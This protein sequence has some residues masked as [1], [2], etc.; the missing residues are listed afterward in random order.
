MLQI[1]DLKNQFVI[2][3]RYEDITPL[4]EVLENKDIVKVGT[5][6]KFDWSRLFKL[7]FDTKNLYDCMINEMLLNCGISRPKGYFSL[8]GMSSRY[9]GATFTDPRQLSLFEEFQLTK[10]T[11]DEFANLGDK[12]FTKAQISY[13]ANDV[14]IPLL[15]KAKQEKLIEKEGLTVVSQLENAYVEV[16]SWMEYSGL[17]I[18]VDMWL[19]NNDR[20][21]AL[22]EEQEKVMN[23]YTDYEVN[24]NSPKQV[25]EVFKKLGV[26]TKLLDKEKTEDLGYDVWKDS[27]ARTNIEKHK[28]KYPIVEDY[29][30]YKMLFK[31]VH[32]Y[33][34]KFLENVNPVTG[35]VHSD[36]WQILNTGRISSANPNCV[37]LDTEVLT[38]EGW[39]TYEK[40]SIGDYIAT[41][42]ENGKLAWKPV[43]NKYVGKANVK[44]YKKTNF[45]MALTDNH[46]VLFQRRKTGKF[47]TVEAKDW[48]KHD[49]ILNSSDLDYGYKENQDLIKLVVASVSDAYLCKYKHLDFSFQK[50]RK[51][52]RLKSILNS[53]GIEYKIYPSKDRLRLK[54]HNSNIPNKLWDYISD[55]KEFTYKILETDLQTRK[56]FFEEI[57]YWDGNVKRHSQITYKS[58]Q[59]ID[60][61]SAV[62][63]TVSKRTH[64]RMYKQKYPTLDINHKNYTTSCGVEIKDLGK[65][66]VW[67][68]EV[69]DGYFL[70]RRNR[71]TFITGNCQNLPNPE[72]R[73]GFRE[74]FRVGNGYK[75]VAADYSQQESRVL[76]DVA[77]EKSM[78]EFFTK[79]KNP[80]SHSFIASK[81]FGRQITKATDPLARSMG[82]QTGFTIAYGGGAHKLAEYFQITVKEGKELIKFYFSAFP[83]LKKYFKKTQEQ[84]LERGHIL[85]DTITGRKNYLD[86]EILQLAQFVAYFK[87]RGYPVPYELENKLNSKVAKIKRNAQNYPIQGLSG[88]MTKLA[89]IYFLD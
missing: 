79:N 33:G 41:W 22:L 17:P 78:I 29:L 77:N 18:D 39:R 75:M 7:G 72:R 26:P 13:G 58:I 42:S 65:I 63:A 5:N 6:L 89:G 4:K 59:N 86:E 19:E 28:S 34:E 23:S 56:T 83:G 87:L 84:A 48:L 67:C 54:V 9:L 16:I 11:R 27:V 21:K 25:I 69:K 35:R 15:I 88:S 66:G 31:L 52:N 64:F 37:S 73:V 32:S 30:E 14:K 8:A 50:E 12:P 62:S 40:V 82:K 1:G 71:Q 24:W 57:R 43:L 61:I 10:G 51:F 20:Y 68:V 3:T 53:L 70:A 45:D 81:M 2:D 74:C 46:R 85:I 60:V 38:K 49:H 44:E 36:Y 80:D 55:R 76:A 47:V